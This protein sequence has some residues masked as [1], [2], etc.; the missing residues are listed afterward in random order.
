MK[1][2]LIK[3]LS[4]TLITLLMLFS[5]TGCFA[6][7]LL[8][9]KEEADE[10]TSALNDMDID[11][12]EGAQDTLASVESYYNDK[13]DFGK[14]D[15]IEEYIEQP[16]VSSQLNSQLSSMQTSQYG[17]TIEADDNELI[18]VFKYKNA[19]ADKNAARNAIEQ[20]MSSVD[21]YYTSMIGTLQAMVTEPGVSITIKYLDAD[22]SLI[23]SKTYR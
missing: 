11:D 22:G 17:V 23:Y 12:I 8:E 5:F 9:E 15:N 14:P 10:L 19:L 18:Y 13:S 2:T 6:A 3:V 21:S 20:G 7:R 1:N 4:L 16:S